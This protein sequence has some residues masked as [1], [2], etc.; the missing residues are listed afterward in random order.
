MRVLITQAPLK[1][2]DTLVEEPVFPGE[3]RSILRNTGVTAVVCAGSV[4]RDA[5]LMRFG[6]AGIALFA[7]W[8]ASVR[9][10][11]WFSVRCCRLRALEGV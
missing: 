1:G 3:G 7:M 11:D 6:S 2:E 10:T 5:T 8:R 9:T 4:V